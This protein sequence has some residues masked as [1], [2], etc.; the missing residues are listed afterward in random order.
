[1]ERLGCSKNATQS[2]NVSGSRQ[3]GMNRFRCDSI[4]IKCYSI[5]QEDKQGK[6]MAKKICLSPYCP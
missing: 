6:Q 2:G 1:M 4:H 5:M 3:A